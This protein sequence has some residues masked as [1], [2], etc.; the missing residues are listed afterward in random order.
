MRLLSK[1]LIPCAVLTFVACASSHA[2]A[3]GVVLISPAFQQL[4]PPRAALNIQHDG[5]QP[6]ASGGVLWNGNRDVDFGDISA[7]PHQHTVS[8][9]DLGVGRASDLRVL[10]NIN[11]ANGG[12]KMPITIN[13][14]RLTA[15]D[16][17][18]NAVFSADLVNG[19]PITLN[20][21][22]PAQGSQSD[23]AFGLDADAAARLQAAISQNANLRL[24]LSVS[25]T[26]P[27]GGPERFLYGGA[28]Q[29]VPEP[30]TMVLLGTGLAG[31]A[32]A[33][34]R[35]KLAKKAATDADTKQD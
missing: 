15:Y 19:A 33:V 6:S 4:V 27:N 28:T 35:R 16:S 26:N 21:F 3:D 29:P 17:A 5:S 12:D 24:G 10:M 2:Y 18:G 1:L 25:L 20:Q 11:E 7:G 9:T 8:L 30:T 14:L 22:R 32:G 31:I 13:S 23:Y 34:R